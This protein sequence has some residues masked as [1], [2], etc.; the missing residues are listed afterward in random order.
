VYNNGL[1]G[2]EPLLEP[3]TSSLAFSMPLTR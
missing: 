3:W 2:W 1:M